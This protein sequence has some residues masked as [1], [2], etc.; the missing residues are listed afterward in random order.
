MVVWAGG[1]N[2]VPAAGLARTLARRGHEVGVLGPASLRR[3]FERAG[4]TFCSLRR[5][6]PPG[7]AATNN[8]DDSWLGWSRFIGGRALAED[9]VARLEEDR[10]D[11]VVLDAFL[12]AGFCAAER[13][14]VP[15]VALVHVLY[16]PSV[17]GP[18][19]SQWDLNLPIVERT[20]RG[21]GLADL[22]P[23]EPLMAGLWSRSQ[24]VLA[25]SPAVFD[26]P[27]SRLA[28]HVRY[29]GPILDDPAPEANPD[30]GR[31]V[32]VSFGT[33]DMRQ[34]EVLQRTLDALAPLETEVVCT[35][36]EV[37]I[38]GLRVP[39]NAS[40][41]GFVPHSRILPRASVVVTHA[42]L[43][44]VMTSLASGVPLVCL[45]LGR[46]QPLNA[47]RVADLG[48]GLNLPRDAPTAD[49]RRAVEEVLSDERY[50]ERAGSMRDEIASYGNGERA[51][52]AIETLL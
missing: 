43:S 34:G 41:H 5:A 23:A 52:E 14:G 2:V 50:G 21:L 25:C 44:T 9:V 38:S 7:D 19:A 46:D 36:G 37:P 20:R 16:A 29:V 40:V 35:L 27:V 42:G 13:V 31:L 26:Y 8:F 28:A 47:A 3:R 24:L 6:R 17:E 1:G 12:S 48:L 18:L 39:A 30:G 22:D 49:I 11:V 51:A 15:A 4:S 32:L 10:P 33:T 45:P